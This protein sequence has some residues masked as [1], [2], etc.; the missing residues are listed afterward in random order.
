MQM[1]RLEHMLSSKEARAAFQRH[2][3]KSDPTKM[4]VIDLRALFS[5]DAHVHL[6]L[7]VLLM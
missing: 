6:V 3:H 1:Q 5:W 4:H 7:V 2:V